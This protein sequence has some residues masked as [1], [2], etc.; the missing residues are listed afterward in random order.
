MT[1][2]IQAEKST[3]VAKSIKLEYATHNASPEEANQSKTVR[4]N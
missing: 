4:P 3:T 1:A 2:L